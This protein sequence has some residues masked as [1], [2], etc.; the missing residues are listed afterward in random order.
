MCLLRCCLWNLEG[1]RC[2]FGEVGHR[3]GWTRHSRGL[4]TSLHRPEVT[5]VP[6]SLQLSTLVVRFAP[7]AEGLKLLICPPYIYVFMCPLKIYVDLCKY[8]V[9]VHVCPLLMHLQIW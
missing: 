6:S 4:S 3:D 8:V 7:E 2:A 1:R 5:F 9:V